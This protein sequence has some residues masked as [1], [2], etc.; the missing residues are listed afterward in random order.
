MI[1]WELV[2]YPK[3]IAK[4]MPKVLQDKELAQSFLN[5]YELRCE[6]GRLL[7]TNQYEVA[8]EVLELFL[9]QNLFDDTDQLQWLKSKHLLITNGKQFL[10]EQIL[11]LF[12]A[13]ILT[14]L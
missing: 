8:D 13:F 5:F 6:L 4:M 7:K 10:K 1:C 12:L 3:I 14:P 11:D 2:N 9:A